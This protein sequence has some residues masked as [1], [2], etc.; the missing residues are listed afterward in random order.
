MHKDSHC[1]CTAWRGKP[2]GI[3]FTGWAA[4]CELFLMFECTIKRQNE[5]SLLQSVNNFQHD[6]VQLSRVIKRTKFFFFSPN[7][8]NWAKVSNDKL[9]PNTRISGYIWTSHCWWLVYNSWGGEVGELI[10]LSETIATCLPV[11]KNSLAIKQNK[12]EHVI[13][14]II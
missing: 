5:H 4:T 2:A 11:D 12:T 9:M 14:I 3:E 6:M 7:E 1:K 13:V 8:W 10:D